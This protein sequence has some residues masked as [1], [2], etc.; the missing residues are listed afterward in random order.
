MFSI[1]GHNRVS[2]ALHLLAFE[3]RSAVVADHAALRL[4]A[5]LGVFL[6][7]TIST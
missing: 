6:R 4:F 5:A 1:V 7:V 3:C 2:S